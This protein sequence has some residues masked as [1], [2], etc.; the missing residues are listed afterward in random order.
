MGVGVIEVA[1]TV[2]LGAISLLLL[3]VA[4]PLAELLDGIAR[5]RCAQATSVLHHCGQLD[6]VDADEDSDG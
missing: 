2:L 3:I 6:P 1:G 5:H 4:H